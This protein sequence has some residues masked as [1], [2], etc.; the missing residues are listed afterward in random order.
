MLNFPLACYMANVASLTGWDNINVVIL[1]DSQQKL[2][3]LSLI[4][5][6][7][8]NACNCF[9]MFVCFLWNCSTGLAISCF[10]EVQLQELLCLSRLCNYDWHTF[11]LPG[12]TPFKARMQMC[13]AT[14]SE[15]LFR[16]FAHTEWKWFRRQMFA[17]V[18]VVYVWPYP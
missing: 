5:N 13:L 11:R 15:C 4:W 9:F 7:L 10:E 2:W 17:S 3:M 12:R 16:L 18:H 14:G 8:N 6:Q 1:K